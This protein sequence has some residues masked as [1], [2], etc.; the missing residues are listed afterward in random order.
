MAMI[1]R[2]TFW[3]LIAA[4]AALALAGCAS[5]DDAGRFMVEPDRYV[6]YNCAELAVTA[7]ANATRTHELEVLM[8][9]AEASSGGKLVSG[10]AYQPEY[11]QLRG[12]MNEL[13]KTAAEKNCKST[14]LL[15]APGG[16]V[17]DQ[18]VR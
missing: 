16:R 13:R 4:P 18:V 11:I 8:A 12:E 2:G 9:K 17:S 3:I 15:V 10:I 5:G 6:L 14:P 7:Q 1:G